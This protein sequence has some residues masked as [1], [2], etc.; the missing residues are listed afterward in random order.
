MNS[1]SSNQKKSALSDSGIKALEKQLAEESAKTCSHA[2]RA[3]QEGQKIIASSKKP[4][5]RKFK[6][7]PSDRSRAAPKK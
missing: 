4:D 1:P 5:S 3:I 6:F 2:D 7:P